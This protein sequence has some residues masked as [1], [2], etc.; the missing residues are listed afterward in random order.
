[1]DGLAEQAGLLARG[2]VSS[3]EMVSASLERI[4]HKASLGA[5][6]V[7]RADAA[8]EEARRAD[9]RLAEGSGC[10]CWGCPSPSR[11]TPIWRGRRRRSRCGATIRWRRGTR[12]SCGGCGPPGP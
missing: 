10:R 4:E 8:L 1:M 9:K 2:E 12:R 5:F 7:V 3:V 11:T 6:R